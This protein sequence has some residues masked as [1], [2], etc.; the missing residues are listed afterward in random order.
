LIEPRA[1]ID[2]VWVDAVHDALA[3]HGDAYL[4]RVFT[5]QELEAAAGR[6]RAL[7]ERVAAKEA[8]MKALRPGRDRPLAWRDVEL[9]PD[10][11]AMALHGT[12]A[13]LARA[14]GITA[15]AVSLSRVAGYACAVVVAEATPGG[16]R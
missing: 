11:R 1:G 6:P 13:E 3:E 4:R 10:G 5:E 9:A 12:A 7:A 8:A 2:L 14:G 15:L 16:H